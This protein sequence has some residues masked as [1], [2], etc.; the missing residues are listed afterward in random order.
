VNLFL[1]V[2]QGMGLALA[3]G[4]RPFLPPLLAGALASA[5][6]GLNFDGTDYAFLEAPGFLAAIVLLAVAAVWAERLRATRSL[7]TPIAALAVAIGALEFAG[8]LADEGYAGAP[9]LAAGAAFALLG[10]VASATFLGRARARLETRGD[11][12]STGYLIAYAD[13]AAL[14]LAAVAILVPP[15]AYAALAFCVWV[16]LERRKREGKKYEGLRVLR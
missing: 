5:D 16:L 6:A 15:L 11:V 2:S 8:S 10:F 1:V 4:V 12:G 9:G 14:C 3:S 7:A 13:A